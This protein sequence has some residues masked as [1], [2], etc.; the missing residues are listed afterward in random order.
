MVRFIHAIIKVI[1]E[2]VIVMSNKY[3]VQYTDVNPVYEEGR[4]MF[5]S[6]IIIAV[7]VTIIYMVN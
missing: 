7:I 3:V 6:V 2:G 4:K 5:R 1:K